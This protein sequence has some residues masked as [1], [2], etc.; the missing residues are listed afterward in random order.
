[1]AVP[2][3]AGWWVHVDDAPA[4]RAFDASMEDTDPALLRRHVKNWHASRA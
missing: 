1:M 4:I 2:D 3:D